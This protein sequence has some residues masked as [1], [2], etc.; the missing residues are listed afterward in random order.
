[1]ATLG[2]FLDRVQKRADLDPATF[3]DYAR[4]LRKIAS[5]VIGESANSRKF[6]SLVSLLVATRVSITNIFDPL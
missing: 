6:D 3:A 2:E 1:M 4:A 5:D